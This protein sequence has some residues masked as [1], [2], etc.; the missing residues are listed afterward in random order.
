MEERP[1]GTWLPPCPLCPQDSSCVPLGFHKLQAPVSTAEKH[2]QAALFSI[3][4]NDAVA[5][6][7][8]DLQNC[9]FDGQRFGGRRSPPDDSESGFILLGGAIHAGGHL[10]HLLWPPFLL[11]PLVLVADDLLF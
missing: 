8:L 9:L 11:P 4:V 1:C 3:L 7:L 10:P 2:S 5:I 6:V